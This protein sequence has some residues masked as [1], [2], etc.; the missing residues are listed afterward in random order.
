MELKDIQNALCG[1]QQ[2]NK[3]KAFFVAASGKDLNWLAAYYKKRGMD[4]TMV[5]IDK[6]DTDDVESLFEVYELRN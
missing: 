2:A 3:T 1:K 4:I 6:I 5:C